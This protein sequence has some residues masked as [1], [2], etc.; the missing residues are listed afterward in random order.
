[1]F[2]LCPKSS[3]NLWSESGDLEFDLE[4]LTADSVHTELPKHHRSD[5][6]S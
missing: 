3:A 6:C 4:E 2:L 1:V 5:R